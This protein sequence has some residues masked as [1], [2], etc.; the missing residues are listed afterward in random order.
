[1]TSISP[2]ISAQPQG[3]NIE[4]ISEFTSDIFD[5]ATDL[6]HINSDEN[7]QIEKLDANI[8]EYLASMNKMEIMVDTSRLKNQNQ[9][10]RISEQA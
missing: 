7:E 5:T 8:A 2:S 9:I 3:L 6:S 1:M 10:S 4:N